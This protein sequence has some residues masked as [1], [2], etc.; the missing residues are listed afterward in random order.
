MTLRTV[1]LVS[2]VLSSLGV[3]AAARAADAAAPRS[4][5]PWIPLFDGKTLKG[6]TQKG[7]TARYEVKDGVIVGSTVPNTKNTFLCTE[8]SYG[9]FVLEFEFKVHPQL[10][11]GVQVRGQSRPDYQDGRVHGYQIE[12]DP[13]VKRDR[14]W[15]GGLYDEGRRGWLADLTGND[16]ARKA[17]KPE[18]WNHVRVEAFGPS[19]KT[20]IN[21]VPAASIVDAQDLEG[22]VALQVHQVG[23]REDPLT[24]AWRKLRIQD[25]GR[26]TWRPVFAGKTMKGLRVHPAPAGGVPDAGVAA[27]PW[28]LEAG[29]A[30]AGTPARLVGKQ[31]SGA[32]QASLLLSEQP[33]PKD[34]ILRAEVKLTEGNGGLYLTGVPGSGAAAAAGLQVD[35]DAKLGVRGFYDSGAGKWSAQIA[36]DDKQAA[37][38]VKSW[39]PGA[40]NWLT[41]IAQGGEATLFLNGY[42]ALA[43]K[44]EAAPEA[45]LALELAPGGASALEVRHLELMSDNVPPPVPG[46]PVGWCIRANGSAPE[47]ARAAGMEQLELALQDVLELSDADLDKLAARLAANGLPVLSGYNLFGQA[48]T[49]WKLIGPESDVAKQDQHMDRAFARLAKL[50]ARYVVFN[51]GPARRAPEG[52]DPKQARKALVALG[53][54]MASKARAHKLEVLLE[55]LRRSDTN[56]VNTVTEA[57][58]VAR[59]VGQPNF[60]IVVDHSFMSIEKEDPAV[61][62]KAGRLIRHV[63]LARPEGRTYPVEEDAQHYQ[64]FFAAL[65]AI[66]YQG[67]FSIHARTDNF[68]ADAPRALRFLRSEAAKL[69]AVKVKKPVKMAA[70][71]AAGAN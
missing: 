21:G 6:W 66:R 37:K 13:D 33:L 8:R 10:N 40:W 11:G 64:A 4:E 51:S 36:P 52:M 32:N 7:G 19:I 48:N 57:V 61:L 41:I 50:G 67:G 63:H 29:D 47:E 60:G 18:Q 58:E 53:R 65:A 3:A 24:I 1:L 14:M 30:A 12:I 43:T 34:F 31:A 45:R 49:E 27:G 68:F 26:R 62:R 16:P 46:R 28:S 38:G 71:A 44:L 56:M 23:K 20:F 39:K 70:R 17:F 22:F 5:P 15:T 42:R 35:L 25:H 9:D 59:A 54:R 69:P 55:P 2:T